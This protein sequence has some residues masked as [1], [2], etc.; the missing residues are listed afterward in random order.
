V[1]SHHGTPHELIWEFIGKK[2]IG[3]DEAII[4]PTLVQS[5]KPIRNYVPLYMM[6]RERAE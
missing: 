2:P 1:L 6:M 5:G 3:C 4:G